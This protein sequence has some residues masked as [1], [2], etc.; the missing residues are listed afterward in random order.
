MSISMGESEAFP[1]TLYVGNLDPSVTEELI[2]VLFGQIGTVKGC[3]IIHEPGHEPYCFV[4]FAEHHSAAAALAAMN[5][6]NCMGR[7]MKVNWATSP[8]NAPKQDTSRGGVGCLQKRRARKGPFKA[9]S[10][11]PAVRRS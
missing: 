2:M 3:K 5:K 7:E 10:L 4:E 9:L 8:G 1:R 6:R 11:K